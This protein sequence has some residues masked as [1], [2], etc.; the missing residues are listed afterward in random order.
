[1]DTKFKPYINNST[2]RKY[3]LLLEL[4]KPSNTNNSCIGVLTLDSRPSPEENILSVP[5]LERKF[6]S[7]CVKM[8][9]FC[10]CRIWLIW[11]FLK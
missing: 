5:S 10:F 3:Y 7:H 8:S 4:P 9:N 1:M 11:E 2:F 6:K